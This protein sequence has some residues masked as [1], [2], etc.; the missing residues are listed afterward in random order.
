M[1]VN[2]Q[3]NAGIRMSH[4]ILQTFD[5]QSGLLHVGAEGMPQHMG[6]YI[7][8]RI[9]KQFHILRLHTPHVVFQMHG[10]FRPAVLIQKYKATAP[11][12][13]HLF[14]YVASGT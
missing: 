7:G 13:Q 5:I 3:G 8:E 9:A 10:H 6:R 4:Q 11:I 1:C 14:F 12:H 2:I